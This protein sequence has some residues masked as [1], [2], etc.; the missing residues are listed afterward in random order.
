[1]V[2]LFLDRP[3][4]Q[5]V[6][7]RYSILEHLNHQ[8]EVLKRKEKYITLSLLLFKYSYL[9]FPATTSPYLPP[10][11]LPR[12]GF[13]DG[14]F[15]HVPYHP[16]PSFYCYPPHPSPLVTVSLFF[17]SMSLVMFSLLVCFVDQVPLEGGII[18]YLSFT[19]WLISLSIM[20]SSSV[21][22]VTKGRSSFFLSAA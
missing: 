1:M 17:I 20:L 6:V 13:I 21:H 3:H 11:I 22:V 10:S 8:Q 14:S 5:K 19:I 7:F 16:S 4:I 2:V 15:I 12:F 18:W 9:P